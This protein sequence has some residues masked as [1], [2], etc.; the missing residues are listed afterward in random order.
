MNTY[1]AFGLLI[2]SEIAIEELLSGSEEEPDVTVIWGKVPDTFENMAVDTPNLKISKDKYYS[3]IKNVARYYAEKGKLI[4]IE[5][6]GISCMEDVKLYLLGSCMGATLFQR[7]RLPLHGSC[8][9]AGEKGILL[10][11]AS[12]AGKSTVAAVLMKK[13]CR[14]ITDDL[15]AIDFNEIKEP[16]VY[17]AYP[18]QKLW[19]DSIAR[20][21]IEEP[22]LSLNRLSGQLHKYNVKRAERFQNCI[23]PVRMI[24]EIIPS[25]I[26]ELQVEEVKGTRKLNVVFQN[27]Y[28]KLLVEAMELREWYF[29]SCVAVANQVRVYKIMRPRNGHFENEIADHILEL[30]E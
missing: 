21:G 9:I 13:G 20:I 18:G 26:A 5:P 30:V 19:E 4:I 11:G 28:R 27:T 14:M 17:P 3:D 16:I 12:G 22:K 2:Q 25:D 1:R 10:T 15:A 29:G 6:N 8:I 7:R 23:A 24:V